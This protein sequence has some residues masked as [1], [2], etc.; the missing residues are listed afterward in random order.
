MKSCSCSMYIF[1]FFEYSN[2]MAGLLLEVP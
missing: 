2:S 1:V